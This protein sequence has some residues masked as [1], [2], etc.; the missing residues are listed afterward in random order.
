MG[1]WKIESVPLIK[2]GNKIDKDNLKIEL[3]YE[4]KRF[5]DF[6]LSS[7]KKKFGQVS[8]EI[9][10]DNDINFCYKLDIDDAII[11]SYLYNLK[12]INLSK[13]DEQVKYTYRNSLMK[14]KLQ[15]LYY[16]NTSY[17][18]KDNLNKITLPTMNGIYGDE[19]KILIKIPYCKSLFQ[20][21]ELKLNNDVDYL[22]KDTMWTNI[23]KVLK[24]IDKKMKISFIMSNINIEYL[25]E[26]IPFLQTCNRGDKNTELINK[27]LSGDNMYCGKFLI[28][29]NDLNSNEIELIVETV[30][31][32]INTSDLVVDNVYNFIDSTENDVKKFIENILVNLYSEEEVTKISSI[33][34]SFGD[35]LP[36]LNCSVYKPFI[37]PYVNDESIKIDKKINKKY[38][39]IG[40][41][42]NGNNISVS[43]RMLAQ[44][45]FVTGTT[46]SG[47]S[48]FIKEFIKKL[49]NN[50]HLMIIDPIKTEYRDYMKK[51]CS[52]ERRNNKLF[53]FDV[54]SNIQKMNLFVV[55][56]GVNLNSHIAFIEKVL[57]CL[58][59]TDDTSVYDYVRGMLNQTYKNVIFKFYN[60]YIEQ[61]CTKDVEVEIRKSKQELFEKCMYEKSFY[62]NLVQDYIKEKNCELKSPVPTLYDFMVYGRAWLHASLNKEIVKRGSEDK[63]SE[64]IK[65][66]NMISRNSV[67]IYSY[68]ERWWMKIRYSYPLFYKVFNYNEVKYYYEFID[69]IDSEDILIL[70]NNIR[71]DNEKKAF[72]TYFVGVLDEYRR[73]IEDNN[74]E[75]V[76]L[77]IL[78]EA[79][80]IAK[81]TEREENTYANRKTS[82]L[83]SNMLSEI[84]AFGEGVVL[85]EQSATKIIKD[86]IINTS[87]KVIKNVNNGMDI[88]YLASASGMSELEKNILPY[89]AKDEAVIYAAGAGSPMFVK[90][91]LKRS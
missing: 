37:I 3:Y 22:L 21:S 77:T 50:I 19:N 81:N 88:D 71:D 54:D 2:T 8:F 10:Y 89:L 24:V 58:I 16:G 76:H 56:N 60:S 75:L 34:Y 12:F 20:E 73:G 86:A 13:C 87:I 78:E 35:A 28:E 83:V 15:Y 67:E 62:Y 53:L 64:N 74:N 70:L 31:A 33:P 84:R 25:E 48:T 46:G 61:Y 18:G 11:D 79:H 69:K 66:I 26:Y 4:L 65:G 14:K 63:V 82:E 68:F 38:I 47:K 49:P 57:F 1:R 32:D 42:K 36:V 30:K 39:S 55:P 40:E 80:S 59:Q 85:V 23:L 90:N 5:N 17:V 52:N 9:E 43:T 91:R 7:V 41:L 29:H 44:H 51:V 72:F 27:L 6:L 45:M